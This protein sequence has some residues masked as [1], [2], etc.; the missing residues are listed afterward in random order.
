MINKM[1]CIHCLQEILMV[2]TNDMYLL[3]Y[4]KYS[5]FLIFLLLFII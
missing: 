1:A 5:Y 4:M 2:K 3:F